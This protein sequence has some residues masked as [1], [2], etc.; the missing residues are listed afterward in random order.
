MGATGASLAQEATPEWVAQIRPDHPRLFINADSWPAV[1]AMAEGEMAEH[2]AKVKAVVEKLPAE[3]EE[4]D[5]GFEAQDAAFVYLV[6]GEQNY[7]DLT[8]RLLETSVRFY[9]ARIAAG[10]AVN[11]YTTTRV[12][13]LA[14][15]DWI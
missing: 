2:Y 9:R 6:T 5:Y 13:A 8:K 15:F 7:L 10:K 4:K 14:A 11:W 3:L 1:R 12:G